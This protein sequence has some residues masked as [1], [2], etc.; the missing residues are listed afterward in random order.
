ML[1]VGIR[2]YDRSLSVS[3]EHAEWLAREL[4]A[5]RPLDVTHAAEAAATRIERALAD[6]SPEADAEASADGVRV[7]LMALQD[8]AEAPD[9]PGPL[10]ALHD[11]LVAELVRRAR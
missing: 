8:L 2:V 7:L 3:V 5:L 11:A 10:Q 4:R 6:G 9:P 1:H